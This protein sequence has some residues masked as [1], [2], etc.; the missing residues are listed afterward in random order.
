MRARL[1]QIL[2]LLGVL[3]PLTLTLS[4]CGGA[5]PQKGFSDLTSIGDD[6]GTTSPGKASGFFVQVAELQWPLTTFMHQFYSPTTPCMVTTTT[7][8]NAADIQCMLNVREADLYYSDLKWEFNAPPGMCA[9][10]RETPYFYYNTMPGVGPQTISVT[11]GGSPS[12]VTA[13]SVDGNTITPSGG[14]CSTNEV[15][16]DGS[17]DPTC[18]YDYSKSG[19][20]NCCEGTYTYTKRTDAD[21]TTSTL[22]WGG[23]YGNC[24][25]GV[26][27]RN[28]WPVTGDSKLPDTQVNRGDTGVNRTFTA[29][30]AIGSI[31][32]ANNVDVAN[33]WGWTEYR[34]GNQSTATVPMPLRARVDNAN[35]N[36]I[37]PNPAYL[38]E[39]VGEAGELRA[40][41]RLYVNEWNTAEAFSAYM[42]GSATARPDVGGIENTG[43]NSE[44][45]SGGAC[46]DFYSWGSNPADAVNT[47]F[48]D[49][50]NTYPNW[51]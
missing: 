39:C 13:C 51:K 2:L 16:I 43:C 40:R 24:A 25:R 36:P 14:I 22:D 48:P 35:N 18:R 17:G 7:T 37:I 5:E 20:G 11:V 12:A 8:G 44:G 46:D 42:A 49:L 26:W 33:F 31:R 32:G 9:W 3:T 47:G 30:K 28:G 34:A 4:G 21:V 50:T 15:T 45:F 10:I 27:T 19:R 41:I 23:S 6:D 38:Y 1:F 29:S